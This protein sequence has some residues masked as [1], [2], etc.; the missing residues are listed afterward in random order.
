[1]VDGAGWMPRSSGAD[2]SNM[3][4]PK[5]LLVL[6]LLFVVRVRV[7]EMLPLSCACL[8]SKHAELFFET[9]SQDTLLTYAQSNTQRVYSLTVQI[10]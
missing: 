8:S 3:A 10:I 2:W 7:R 6:V 1:M 5:R 4:L 9:V